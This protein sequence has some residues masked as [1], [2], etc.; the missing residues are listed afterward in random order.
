MVERKGPVCF[1]GFSIHCDFEPLSGFGPANIEQVCRRNY[2]VE[3]VFVNRLRLPVEFRERSIHSL[4]DTK[5][6]EVAPIGR[7]QLSA[8]VIPW[9][10]VVIRDRFAAQ[11]IVGA[12]YSSRYF[13]WPATVARVVI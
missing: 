12:Q 3:R 9:I 5:F 7:V 2:L 8:A 1:R 6:V 10:A 4:V 11:V 13:L